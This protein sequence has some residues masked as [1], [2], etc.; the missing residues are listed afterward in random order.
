M[1]FNRVDAMAAR[2]ERVQFG[3]MLV[4]GLGEAIGGLGA[5]AG[6]IVLQLRNRPV[7]AGAGYGF[8]QGGVGGEEIVADK[9]RNL[10][11]DLIVFAKS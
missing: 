7:G 2:I 4:G 3:W 6:A 1:E 9:V 8:A 5:D 10:V 11:F